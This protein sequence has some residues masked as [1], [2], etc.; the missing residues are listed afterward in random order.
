M[1]PATVSVYTHQWDQQ[2]LTP[3][4]SYMVL[5]APFAVWIMLCRFPHSMLQSIELALIYNTKAFGID[6]QFASTSKIS[7]QQ[8]ITI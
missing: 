5:K 2:S 7:I 6:L 3:S 4:H 8:T 1:Y